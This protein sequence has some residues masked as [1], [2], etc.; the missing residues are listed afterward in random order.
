MS[1]MGCVSRV[2]KITILLSSARQTFAPPCPGRWWLLGRI[3]R[4]HWRQREDKEEHVMVCQVLD[5]RAIDHQETAHSDTNKFK[6]LL[7]D[8]PI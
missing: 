6:G 3:I 5:P 1:I 2:G 7:K 8:Y 4:C